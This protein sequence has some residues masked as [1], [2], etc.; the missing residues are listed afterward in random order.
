MMPRRLHPELIRVRSFRRLWCEP[1]PAEP[2][3]S[4]CQKEILYMAGLGPP[5]DGPRSSKPSRVDPD[6]SV[7]PVGTFDPPLHP[8]PPP[9]EPPQKAKKASRTKT[10]TLPSNVRTKAQ[11]Q[12]IL[13]C[14]PT[15]VKELLAAGEL[16]RA[17]SL[18]RETL[19]TVESIEAVQRKLKHLPPAPPTPKRKA[20]RSR[21]ERE[22]RALVEGVDME[23]SVNALTDHLFR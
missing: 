14:G 5:P 9:V 8:S 12:D 23:A 1:K 15:V 18:G 10:P 16:E 7:W 6:M 11:V 4:D 19:I 13:H 2:R 22:H 3:M 20:R 17:E 21:V